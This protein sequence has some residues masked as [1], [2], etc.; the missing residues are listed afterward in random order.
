[1]ETMNGG[2]GMDHLDVLGVNELGT[3]G[4][5]VTRL[6]PLRATA[7]GDS[8]RARSSSPRRGHQGRSSSSGESRRTT[9]IE[10]LERN[11]ASFEEKIQLIRSKKEEKEAKKKAKALTKQCEE[12]ERI[13]REQ[14]IAKKIEKE[15]R[16]EVKQM[17]L[18]KSVEVQLSLK[19]GELRD[20]IRQELRRVIKG[21][22][23]AKAPTSSDDDSGSGSDDG[24]SEL[25]PP[26]GRLTINEKRKWGEEPFF[27]DSPPLVIL[28]KCTPARRTVMKP[29]KLT[30]RLK[31]HTLKTKSHA[32][33]KTRCRRTS[34]LRLCGVWNGQAISM[35]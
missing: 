5:S 19:I 17:E 35:P 27:E 16:A 18:A 34:T 22:S 12:A 20:D 13:E 26:T 4:T 7:S 9:E 25:S 2:K 30:P 14:S 8:H 29:I 1:M 23:K 21:K 24:T 28:P 31:S 3:M 15:K 33:V 10:I 11:V 6:M 32:K